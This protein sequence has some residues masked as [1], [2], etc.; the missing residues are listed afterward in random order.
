[1][2]ITDALVKYEYA[3]ATM[4][5]L[6]EHLGFTESDMSRLKLIWDAAYNDGYI[7][8][9]DEIILTQ[10]TKERAKN[11]ITNFLERKLIGCDD[12]KLDL[13]YIKID[14][15]HDLVKM[16]DNVCSSNLRSKQSNRGGSNK[17]YYAVTGETYE[18]LIMKANT[19]GGKEARKLYRRVIKLAKF[20]RDYIMALRN[21]IVTKQLEESKKQLEE[22]RI[23]NTNMK[24]IIDNT[25]PVEKGTFYIAT[26]T[27]YASQN[28]FKP[29]HIDK[30][31]IKALKQR[32]CQ[33][34]TG[35]TGNDKFYFCFIKEVCYSKS[36]D[37]RVKN[38]LK[39]YKC[40]GEDK[41][42]MVIYP[43][44]LLERIIDN[45]IKNNT[46]DYDFLTNIEATEYDA[47]LKRTPTVPP[48]IS[49]ESNQITFI[50]TEN[51]V[52]VL[53]TVVDV[54]NLTSDERTAKLKEALNRF[55]RTKKPDIP[56]Y[57]CNSDTLDDPITIPWKDF[58]Q[59]LADVLT[60]NLNKLK[61]KSWQ[62]PARIVATNAGLR[63]KYR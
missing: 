43:Y 2:S 27:I 48:P 24:C 18:D 12:Y 36:I 41:K 34:N 50:E 13:D 14:K 29:G 63:F 31:D 53:L 16:Y 28:I 37:V 46:D 26:S 38:I 35:K 33:Y 42:E 9:S 20:M 39:Q 5:Q 60:I 1:M 55:V 21:Y 19:Q 17:Q 56:E 61:P 49:L 6:A 59:L 45:T 54:S 62:V 58:K 51:D 7:Y 30:T 3:E 22:S 44:N 10:L 23:V 47:H 15:N 4:D 11:A 32:L 40:T 57:D 8:L 25:K 52:E